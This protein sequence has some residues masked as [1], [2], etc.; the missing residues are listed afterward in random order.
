MHTEKHTYICT[1]KNL[2]SREHSTK[3]SIASWSKIFFSIF[4]TFIKCTAYLWILP[5]YHLVWKAG[6]IFLTLFKAEKI[7]IEGLW[8][9]GFTKEM[10][11]PEIPLNP[12]FIIDFFLL[13][14]E[15]PRLGVESEL[16]LL[17]Y[18][19]TTAMTNP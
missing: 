12:M 9:F 13:L 15:V 11:E 10:A 2:A 6:N 1:A 19:T 4:Y 18:T 14:M 17:A 16:G 8:S 5:I 3:Y 7:E